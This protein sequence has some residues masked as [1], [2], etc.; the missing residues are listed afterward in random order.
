M[1]D[2]L[3][4]IQQTIF[5][6]QYI[7]LKYKAGKLQT[8]KATKSY[9]PSYL[10]WAVNLGFTVLFNHLKSFSDSISLYKLSQVHI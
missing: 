4:E 3:P 7:A 10:I 5:C 6:L 9:Q 1:A 8:W 2:K